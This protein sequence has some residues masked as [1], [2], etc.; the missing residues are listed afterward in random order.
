M[1]LPVHVAGLVD[2]SAEPG[3]VRIALQRLAEAQPAAFARVA[4]DEA[5]A[6][7]VV[8]VLAASRSLTRVLLTD[9]AAIEALD[10]WEQPVAPDWSSEDRLVGW[11]RR[12]LLRLAAAD[13][14]EALDLDDVGRG[15]ARLA[16]GVLEGACTL[17]GAAGLTV[18]G[19]GKLGAEELNYASD[20]DVM[21]VGPEEQANRARHVLRI[22]AR[23]FRVDAALRPEGRDG[24][25]VR[26]LASFETYWDRWAEPWEF[27]ALLKARPVA[28]DGA[29]GE[30]W[31][32][33]ATDRLWR[34]QFGADE[35]R[36]LRAMKVRAEEEMT[37]R[38]LADREVK[39]GRGGI[40]DIEF[41][42]QLLQLVHGPSDAGLRARG[43]LPAL[44]E[45]GAAGYVDEADA[46]VFENA[47]RF[48]RTVEHRL[49]LVDEQQVH[50]VPGDTAGRERLARVL[51]YRD[52]Q[53]RTALDGFDGD[54]RR[55]QTAARSIHERLYFRPLL[56]AFGERG[57]LPLPAAA[58]R[59]AAFGFTDATRT[60]AALAELTRGLTRRS[61]L[62]EQ[63]LPLL[64]E[65][66][67]EAPDP[68]LGL[69]GLRNLASGQHRAAQL[70][71]AFRDSPETARQLCRLL[72]T[73]PLVHLRF[74]RQPELMADVA[75]EP[76]R[77]RPDRATLVDRAGAATGW[78]ADASYR[79]SGLRTFAQREVLRLQVRDV[80]GVD[81]V[82][83]SEAGL[84]AVA[85]AVLEAALHGVEGFAIVGVGRFGGA[86]LSYASDL[87]VLFVF[88]PERHEPAAAEAVAEEILLTVGGATP[89]DR[90]FAMDPNLRPEGKDGALARSLDGYRAYYGR[91]AAIWERQAM[92]RARPVAGDRAL[93]EAFMALLEDFV[94]RPELTAAQAR[95]IRQMKARI[96]RERI[97]RRDDP[98]FHLKLGRGSLSDVEWTVQLL[99]LRHRVRGTS[100]MAALDALV[101]SGLVERSDGRVLAEAYRYCEHTRNRLLLVRGRPGDALP[102]RADELS[103]LARSLETS[104]AG[105]RED[106]RRVTRRARAVVERLFYEQ[107]VTPR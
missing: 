85:E 59:L 69:L 3:V 71:G 93:G 23:C 58:E 42:V 43:T 87:D 7:R 1:P 20:I 57:R 35:L 11:K 55:H 90:I 73:T 79:R 84:T 81:D 86:E 62:M 54:L 13:L 40:R 53:S 63:M 70:V 61:R 41:A 5:V 34:R 103:R 2:R 38:G 50:A 101:G 80:L 74:E 83:D 45:L 100:T 44:R 65:W 82:P 22:A 29:G 76:G 78:R 15:L 8:A 17:A 31:A 52:D 12:E 36:Q 39:R 19:M 64:L 66:L 98:Q 6:R 24:P 97:P 95:E 60:R 9:P 10:R 47:Y 26:S 33:A 32:A 99:Q 37:R 48:L 75:I 16:E 18:I 51:G 92:V 68:D 30:A 106:Y 4:D 25:L 56:E 94:W 46:G 96:E 49:Q 88:D 105:L 104:P 27:Q 21:F 107:P 67:S 102:A 28:G 14:S 72:G 77:R 89:S 91:W